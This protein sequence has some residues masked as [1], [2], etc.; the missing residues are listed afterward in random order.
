MQKY[1]LSVRPEILG[2]YEATEGRT[3]DAR[4]VGDCG[5]GHAQLEEARDFILL[6]VERG[7]ADYAALTVTPDHHGIRLPCDRS[8]ALTVECGARSTERALS[9]YL[10]GSS[11]L[12][13]VFFGIVA[14]F[15]NY[16]DQPQAHFP[17]DLNGFTDV[18][19]TVSTT[20]LL[21]QFHPRAR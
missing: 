2:A 4:D 10:I 16:R 15:G 3:G 1:T 20:P 21:R 17:H 12:S 18:S 13:A 6:A 7:D 8:C 5:L 14:V 9:R 11:L 19:A